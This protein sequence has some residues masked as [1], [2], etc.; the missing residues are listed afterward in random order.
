MRRNGHLSHPSRRTSS[1]P[2]RSPFHGATLGLMLAAVAVVVSACSS[3]QTASVPT[4]QL[5]TTTA[6]ETTTAPTTEPSTSTTVDPRIAE[7]EA[8]VDRFIET[9]VAVVVDDSIPVESLAGVASTE[10]AEQLGANVLRSRAEGRVSVGDFRWG[11]SRVEFSAPDRALVTR[12]GLDSVETVSKSGALI[13][14]ADTE[15]LTRTYV[16][17]LDNSG[18][19]VESYDFVEGDRVPCE[20]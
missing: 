3:D 4:L 5:T 16:V 2:C 1:P 6:P 17:A 20:L 18:W 8:A 14:P 12:C 19:R 7:V 11:N 13:A 15:A 9:L 10:F